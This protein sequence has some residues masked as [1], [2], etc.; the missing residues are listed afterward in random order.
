[1][2][3]VTVE[4]VKTRNISFY[5]NLKCDTLDTLTLKVLYKNK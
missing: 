3:V 5:K 1:M 4:I 2:M